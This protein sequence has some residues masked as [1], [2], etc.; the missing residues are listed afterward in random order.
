M[1]RR[2][3]KKAIGPALA[4]VLLVGCT[5]TP[6]V[7]D[8][9]T[10]SADGMVIVYVPGGTS[11][12]GSDENDSGAESDE[13]PQHTVTLDGFWIDRT[14]VTNAQYRQCV[15]AG[16]CH[17]PEFSGERFA[18]LTRDSYYDDPAY[19][20]YPVVHVDWYQAEAY[21]SWA[22]ARLPTEAEWE[23]AARGEQGSIYPWGDDPPDDT[24]LN[25]DDS[26]GLPTEVGS[27]PDGASWCGALDMAGNVWEWVA[28]WYGDYPSEAHEDRIPE[29]GLE[30]LM[31][32]W[33]G[34]YPSGAQTNPTGPA[35]G[36]FKVLR[37]GTYGAAWLFVRVAY[38][39]HVMPQ[40]HSSDSGFRCAGV[41][42]AQ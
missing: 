17:P 10:R 14:E 38:R 41:A 3:S 27:Y 23:Y 22:G 42:P 29:E 13:I 2:L 39:F 33:Y 35:T 20:D 19:D 28:D 9:Q 26:V 6:G 37:G 32:E 11:Q 21:C 1:L 15:E 7:G 34:D 18:V 25:Y 30:E 5:P 24:L 40:D 12:M 8:T 36:Q 31:A 4:L 16:A